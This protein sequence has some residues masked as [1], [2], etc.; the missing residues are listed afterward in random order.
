MRELEEIVSTLERGNIPLERQISLVRR[1]MALAD[2]CD[3]TL[4]RAEA[5]LEQLVATADGELVLQRVAYDEDGDAAA[6][7]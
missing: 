2:Q 3:V 5:T 7:E 4:T 1:G 6:D